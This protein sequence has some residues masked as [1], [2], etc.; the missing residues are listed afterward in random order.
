[1]N[2][3]RIVSDLMREKA[4]LSSREKE[5]KCSIR[6]RE[7]LSTHAFQTTEFFISLRE[8]CLVLLEIVRVQERFV[9]LQFAKV[10]FSYCNNITR[11]GMKERDSSKAAFIFD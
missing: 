1:M 11:K 6:E 8:T 2:F 10:N 7:S 9:F 3:G 4:E 5:K